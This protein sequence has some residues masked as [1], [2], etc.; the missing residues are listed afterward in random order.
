MPSFDEFILSKMTGKMVAILGFGR[1]GQSGFSL[2]RRLF[3]TAQIGIFDSDGKI[4]ENP[5][6][7]NDSFVTICTGKSYL[8]QI[9]HYDLILRSPGI[10]VWH[11]LSDQNGGEAG[12]IRTG[13]ITSQTDL[14]LQFFHRQVI[15]VTGTKGKSTTASL[16]A[17]ILKTSGR[18]TI[19]AGNIGNPVFHI[20]GLVGE[21]TVVVLE[22][23]SHQ[24]EFLT[25]GP[26]IAVMLNFFQ[27]HLDAYSS[28]DAYQEAKLNITRYQTDEDFLV[29]SA[30]DP[31]LTEKTKPFLPLRKVYPFSVLSQHGDGLSMENDS[32]IFHHGNHHH[33]VWHIHQDRFLKGTH[34][35][36]NIMAAATVAQLL[37]ICHE[38]LEDGIATFKGLEHR[39]E[40]VGESAGI[41]FYND[42]I[43]TIPEACI[44]AIKSIPGV[45]TLVAG[46]F[47]RGID[48]EPLGR[49]LA[50]S[51]V[52]HFI[53]TGDA[54]IRIGSAIMAAGACSKTVHYIRRF[55][56]FAEIAF[57]VTPSGSVCLL[58]P[59]AASYD[60]FR[61][62][63]E[64]GRRFR[65]LTVNRTL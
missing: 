23:S 22:L 43:A 55:D 42:S 56:E 41:H 53:L 52:S 35:L 5:L 6:L 61:N 65:A 15:G 32:L 25:R 7:A 13:K 38:D 21:E 18:D 39:L 37:D 17:N 44:E 8:D 54:G 1:E 3:P 49:F 14:F 26:H 20:A 33:P 11:L 48:Y 4:R 47:D 16:I 9:D 45:E 36:K 28:Y 58:S 31:I 50:A 2:I 46:G 10:P 63:E 24:L 64:R 51:D 27:E 59:A 57:R 29:F 40:Y 12:R 30:D 34:N 19:L 62:F 60:E